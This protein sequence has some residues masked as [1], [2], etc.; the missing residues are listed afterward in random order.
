MKP[1]PTWL[2]GD[3]CKFPQ[4]LI[5]REKDRLILLKGPIPNVFALR[6]WPGVRGQPTALKERRRL[7]E[8]IIGVSH[9]HEADA[10]H[11]LP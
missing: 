1:C 10:R 3:T 9:L 6:E 4:I 11:H 8:G 5:K 2:A 7:H